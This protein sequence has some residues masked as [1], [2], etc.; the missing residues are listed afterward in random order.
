MECKNKNIKYKSSVSGHMLK[1]KER[2]LGVK[3]AILDCS[4]CKVPTTITNVKEAYFKRHEK[5]LQGEE[6]DKWLVVEGR[7]KVWTFLNEVC[8]HSSCHYLE[9]KFGAGELP[10]HGNRCYLR[11]TYI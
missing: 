7:G 4:Y 11:H 10:H 8:F 1:I 3:D 5:E 2:V 6:W 9:L